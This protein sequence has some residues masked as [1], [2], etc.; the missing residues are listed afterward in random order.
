[1]QPKNKKVKKKLLSTRLLIHCEHLAPS[2]LSADLKDVTIREVK[3]SN[4]VGDQALHSRLFEALCGS[5]AEQNRHRIFH[6]KAIWL[7]RG[8]IL[9]RLFEL[10][11]ESNRFFRK[12]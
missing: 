12:S 9:V 7:F 3:N 10:R 8:S 5:M 4:Y 1:M 2:K 6:A 11:K